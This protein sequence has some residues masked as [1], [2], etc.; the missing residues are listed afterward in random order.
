MIQSLEFQTTLTHGST[1][2]TLAL[3][4]IKLKCSCVGT[5]N[6]ANLHIET[7][8]LFLFHFYLFQPKLLLKLLET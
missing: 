4:L 5:S 1:L 7:I 6:Q 8:I 2:K 3:T